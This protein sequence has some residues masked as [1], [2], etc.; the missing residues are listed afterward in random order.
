MGDF[1]RVFEI[2]PVFRAE[3]ARTHR[4][5]SEF[6]GAIYNINFTV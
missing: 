1:E 3:N 6:T 4:H 5:M 2:G